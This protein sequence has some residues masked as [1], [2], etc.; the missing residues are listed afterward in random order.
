LVIPTGI[1]RIPVFLSCGTFSQESRFL[2]LRNFLGTSLGILSVPGL[3]Y[4]AYI[5][6]NSCDP[7]QNYVPPKKSS[8]KHR[9]K[10]KS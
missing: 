7:L 6:R 1:L 10:K 3:L 2:F 4:Q 9:E 5:H 8:G